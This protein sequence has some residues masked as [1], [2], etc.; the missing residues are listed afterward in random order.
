MR[1]EW[2]NELTDGGSTHPPHSSRTMTTRFG[3]LLRRLARAKVCQHCQVMPSTGSATQW[4]F[5]RFLCNYSRG[6][7]TAAGSRL[8]F[9]SV[10]RCLISTER[11]VY[12]RIEIRRRYSQ[13]PHRY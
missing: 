3:P 5:P 4:G 10:N 7:Q 2:V 1:D 11:C 13:F 8:L 6:R 9:Y 12:R